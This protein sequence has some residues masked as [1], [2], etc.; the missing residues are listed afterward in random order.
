LGV[1]TRP[2]E[3]TVYAGFELQPL[4][5]IA[6]AGGRPAQLRLATCTPPKDCV[7]VGRLP[8]DLIPD[9]A[10]FDRL[11]DLHP[12]E[13]PQI[14]IHGRLVR[15]PRWQQSY[16]HDYRYSGQENA[17]LPIPDQLI[18]YREF[19]RSA[20]DSRLNGL[21]LNWYDGQ[22]GH[23]IGHHRDITTGL[24]PGSPIVTISLGE[25]RVFRLKPWKARGSCF[26]PNRRSRSSCSKVRSPRWFRCSSNI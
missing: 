8:Q 10:A 15:T 26:H 5:E 12:A 21:L 2:S 3:Q 19:A 13:Y 16:G 7:Y 24:I 9:N 17:A 18:P 6:L 1:E 25:D 11:W 14:L 23:Y 4:D 22:L 20:I